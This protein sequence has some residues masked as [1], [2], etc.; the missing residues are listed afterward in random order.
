MGDKT[1]K[2]LREEYYLWVYGISSV[3]PDA[4]IGTR[5]GLAGSFIVKHPL[6][7]LAIKE[8]GSA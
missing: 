7:L 8:S 5:L 6:E 1:F 4:L 2:N 3:N